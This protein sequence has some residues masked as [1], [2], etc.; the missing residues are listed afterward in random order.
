LLYEAVV[1]QR[2]AWS[3][4]RV[5]WTWRV[6]AFRTKTTA[7]SWVKC[8][9]GHNG[10]AVLQMKIQLHENTTTDT[11]FLKPGSIQIVSISSVCLKQDDNENTARWESQILPG[12]SKQW[13]CNCD[14]TWPLCTVE[15]SDPY[16]SAL[17]VHGE[18]SYLDESSKK[19]LNFQGLW[20]VQVHR[21][22]TPL[23]LISSHMDPAHIRIYTTCLKNNFHIILQA[24]AVS[25]MCNFFPSR[26]V[27]LPS[28][29]SVCYMLNDF[30]NAGTQ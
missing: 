28:Y 24:T 5:A 1:M 22:E 15:G 27:C 16:H 4:R 23:V 13:S 12:E 17:H 11:L 21:K 2:T 30:T 9:A 20:E 19:L 18:E 29:E 6:L 10:V 14:F 3:G 25:P 8:Q 7:R 26:Y